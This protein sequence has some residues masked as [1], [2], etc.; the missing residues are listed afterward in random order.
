MNAEAYNSALEYK[1]GDQCWIENYEGR[2]DENGGYQKLYF[3]CIKYQPPNSF[4]YPLIPVNYFPNDPNY[5]KWLEEQSQYWEMIW[6]E[7]KPTSVYTLGDY[8]THNGYYYRT[9]WRWSYTIDYDRVNSP[10]YMSEPIDLEERQLSNELPPNELEDEH[11]IR[12]WF[13]SGTRLI[14]PSF[15]LFPYNL[16]RRDH[17]PRYDTKIPHPYYHPKYGTGEWSGGHNDGVGFAYRKHGF[18]M[19]CYQ[20]YEDMYAPQL[21]EEGRPIDQNDDGTINEDDDIVVLAGGEMDAKACGVGLQHKW[22]GGIV[23]GVGITAWES[24]PPPYGNQTMWAWVGSTYPSPDG[25]PPFVQ[26]EYTE[27]NARGKVFYNFNHPL[28]FRRSLKVTIGIE[29]ALTHYRANKNQEGV[30][31][32][33]SPVAKWNTYKVT[34]TFQ[35]KSDC[36]SNVML[37]TQWFVA[38]PEDNV[39]GTFMLP[40]GD[41]RRSYP[42]GYNQEWTPWFPYAKV[43][44]DD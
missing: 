41:M 33:Y 17:Y 22:S 9:S 2:A 13:Y 16:E 36:F 8:V 3:N 29:T 5:P 25:T 34:K 35:P 1:V 24:E 4:H 44:R 39:V 28:F 43:E 23:W 7:W 37:E 12:A 6:P 19:E 18:S 31:T 30:I 21:D 42:F 27:E 14:E 11:G 26:T 10:D 32:S 15:G 38:L 20:Y 40:M